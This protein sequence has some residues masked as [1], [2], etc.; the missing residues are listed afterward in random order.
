MQPSNSEA[1]QGGLKGEV[2]VWPPRP[3]GSCSKPDHKRVVPCDNSSAA[4]SPRKQ[5]KQR[6][7]H[8]ATGPRLRLLPEAVPRDN[9]CSPANLRSLAHSIRAGPHNCCATADRVLA[10]AP[11]RAVE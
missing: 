8:S 5:L 7:G 3:R 6:L 10:N 2:Q 1:L 11:G 9:N 4:L